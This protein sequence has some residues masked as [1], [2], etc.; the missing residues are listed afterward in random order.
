MR[1]SVLLDTGPLVAL[2]DRREEYHD[3][4]IAQSAR[5]EWP[6]FTCEPVITEA[7]FLLRDWPK[8]S[9]SV[10]ELLAK[11]DITIAFRL[12]EELKSVANFLTRYADQGVSL[13]DACLVR[14]SEQHG[15]SVVFTLDRQ[16][17]RIY[18][19]HGRQVI[20]TL[21]PVHR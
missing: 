19:R 12:V 7:L 4:S 10:M 21:M 11:G 1:T 9:Q 2:I 5:L 15:Q 14:M 17:V 20:P 6:F 16:F 8:G 3:W 18:R 13:A